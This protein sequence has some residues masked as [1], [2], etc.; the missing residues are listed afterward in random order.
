[1]ADTI[2][3]LNQLEQKLTVQL[4]AIDCAITQLEE[5]LKLNN[6]TQLK[7]KLEQEIKQQEAEIAQLETDIAL[8]R[9]Q[10]IGQ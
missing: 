6:N 8:L 5:A 4:R 3:T 9:N 7:E 1:M 2:T 10:V